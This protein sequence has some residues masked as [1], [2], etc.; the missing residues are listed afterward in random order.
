MDGR[1]P[2]PTRQPPSKSPAQYRSRIDEY[3]RM[4]IHGR[5]I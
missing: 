5:D 1:S 2:S 3:Y 4:A